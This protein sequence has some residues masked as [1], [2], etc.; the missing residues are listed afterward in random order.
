MQFSSYV[1]LYLRKTLR[2]ETYEQGGKLVKTA[3]FWGAVN[4]GTA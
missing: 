3:L 4:I 1:S 2:K